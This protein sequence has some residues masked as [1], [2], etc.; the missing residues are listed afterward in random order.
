MVVS[1]VLYFL[2]S[3]EIWICWYFYLLFCRIILIEIGVV[4]VDRIETQRNMIIPCLGVDFDVSGVDRP[5]E[6]YIDFI[7]STTAG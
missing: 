2:F 7:V 3:F 1:E 6:I 4:D 5:I